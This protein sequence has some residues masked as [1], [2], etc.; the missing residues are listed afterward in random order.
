M[1]FSKIISRKYLDKKVL[2]RLRLL[3]AIFILMVIIIFYNIF[4]HRIRFLLAFSGLLIGIG[5]GF[6]AGRMIKVKWQEKTNKVIT[7]MDGVGVIILILYIIFE[8]NRNA[9]FGHWL[10]GATLTAFGFSLLAGM[11]FGRF[12][13]TKM[14]IEDI[15]KEKKQL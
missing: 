8:Y 5:L 9:I 14:D 7:E 1:V 3:F 4:D 12:M 2:F 15:L 10:E 6:L 11:L 13:S